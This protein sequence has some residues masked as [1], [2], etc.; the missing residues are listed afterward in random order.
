MLKRCLAVLLA[1]CAALCAMLAP[2]CA[3]PESPYRIEV[4]LANQI[5]TIYRCSDDAVV[6]Q[7]IC[8]TGVG[9]STPRGVFH[10]ASR[11][12]DRAEWYF[13]G[14]YQC[15]VKR[16]TRI[17][18]SIL[19]HSLPY[20]EQDMD[21][22]DA[23]AL[24][25]LG[26][27]ASHGCVRLRWEDAEWIALNCPDGTET[28]IFTGASRREGLRQLL[29]EASFTGEDGEGYD[30]FTAALA[31]GAPDALGRGD[32]GE[33]VTALQRMLGALGCFEGPL[34]GVY[35]GATVVAVMR[36]QS[37]NGM[38]ATGVATPAMV[39]YVEGKTREQR[40]GNRE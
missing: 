11:P 38:A 27:K 9:E 24:A 26:S 15:F 12:A 4:D 7:M 25:R 36:F 39:D 32:A 35:D 40:V 16:P 20:A 37:A 14:K 6:R 23:E 28:R 8:S 30:G 19:F 29:L 31:D 33:D 22:I 17:K 18:G 3:A 1:L 10:L 2:A 5:T 13:I 21:S 34:T